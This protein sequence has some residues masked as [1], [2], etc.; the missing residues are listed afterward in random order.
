MLIIFAGLPGTGKTT[1]ARELARQ[2]GAVHLRID[3]VEQAIR[4]S[5]LLSQSI[6]DVGYRVAYAVAEDNLRIG[7]T[8]V[9]DSVNPINLTRDAWVAVANAA[10]VPFIEVEVK[11]LDRDEHRRRVRER[12]ID[13][14]GLNPPTWEDVASREYHAW[15]R[16]HLVVDTTVQTV[17]QSVQVIRETVRAE[18]RERLIW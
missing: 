11:C 2:I 8:V 17:A 1:V 18:H 5:G 4:N 9:A 12:I 10:R 6:N 7:R 14:P 13:V 15:N 3:T 16:E